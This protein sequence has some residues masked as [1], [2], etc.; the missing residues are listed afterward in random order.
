MT[1]TSPA[2]APAPVSGSGSGS[3]WDVPRALSETVSP[4]LL[5]VSVSA[6][7]RAQQL[8]QQPPPSLQSP[9]PL[10]Q[11]QPQPPPRSQHQPPAVGI[12]ARSP[13]RP[14]TQH[15]IATHAAAADPRA[16]APRPEVESAA[17]PAES[18]RHC[19]PASLTTVDA[20]NSA[21]CRL[22]CSISSRCLLAAFESVGVCWRP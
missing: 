11:P 19:G 9:P 17:A 5:S 2:P 3:F 7:A 22:N 13:S 21:S 4:A 8:S 12:R 20:L 16:A 1:A 15:A 10:Q 6:P 14:S 18:L